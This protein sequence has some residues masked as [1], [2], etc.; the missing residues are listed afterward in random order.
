MF[1]VFV[2][3]RCSVQWSGDRKGW[4]GVKTYHINFVL[5]FGR[6][7]GFFGCSSVVLVRLREE[8]IGAALPSVRLFELDT[9]PSPCIAVLVLTPVLELRT[10]ELNKEPMT[11][12]PSRER[13]ATAIVVGRGTACT[14]HCTPVCL[15]VCK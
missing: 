11:N 1:L 8:A 2:V 9:C 4:V 3:V 6:L 15:Y 12:R 14:G 13:L 7:P 10:I 5:G